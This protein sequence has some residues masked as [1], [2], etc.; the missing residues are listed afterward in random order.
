MAEPQPEHEQ[1]ELFAAEHVTHHED[2]RNGGRGRV[3]AGENTDGV[4]GEQKMR[5]VNREKQASPSED[6]CTKKCLAWGQHEA[7]G[8]G[9]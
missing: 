3:K 8:K 5:S 6:Q 1:P 7:T 9:D 4:P 2:W